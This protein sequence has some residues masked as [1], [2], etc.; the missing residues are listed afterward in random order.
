MGKNLLRAVVV[1]LG[2]VLVGVGVESTAAGTAG[3]G[4]SVGALKDPIWGT[5]PETEGAD[6]IWG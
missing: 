3:G 5:A 6:P 1:A 2:L 4:S